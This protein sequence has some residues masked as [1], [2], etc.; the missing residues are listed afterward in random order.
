MST[1]ASASIIIPLSIDK[2]WA[3]LRDFTSI[4]SHISAISCCELEDS[5]KAQQVGAVRVMKWTGGEIRKHR[6][7]ELSDVYHQITWE[8]V[9]ADPPTE[10]LGHI[11]KIVC[12]RVSESNSTFVEWS[13]EFSSGTSNDFILFEQRAYHRNL[14]DIRE[15]LTKKS[16]PLLY[17]IHEGPSTRVAWVAA[18]LGI[19][20]RV[21]I[22][23]PNA[24]AVL[25][26]LSTDKG[27]VVTRYSD[28]DLLLLESGSTVMHLIESHDACH[29]LDPFQ[30][31]TPE[32]AKYLQWFFYTSSTVDHLLFEA[33]KQ[34][35]VLAKDHQDATKIQE[36]RDEWD[37]QVVVELENAV[38]KTPYICGHKLSGADIMCGWSINFAQSIG[39]L[40]GHPILESYLLRLRGI[41]SFQ[42]AFS[43]IDGAPFYFENL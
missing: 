25:S 39:W 27:G 10:T 13:G 34:L 31:G 4:C 17:H 3:S 2:V 18:H 8:L 38:S 35:F 40:E 24:N 30:Q 26:E 1:T 32:R 7:I 23:T 42:K 41:S 20:I 33:Y 37:T 22:V 36:M 12:R 16:L 15:S 5:G 11:S 14:A 6:L 21:K 29:N 9:E 28:G 19:P 43:L